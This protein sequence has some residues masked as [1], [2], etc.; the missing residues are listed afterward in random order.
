MSTYP[1]K[2]KYKLLDKHVMCVN[3]PDRLAVVE[4]D[5]Y[6]CEECWKEPLKRK[7]YSRN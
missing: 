1:R 6:V 3:H 7:R 5:E 2:P 4:T